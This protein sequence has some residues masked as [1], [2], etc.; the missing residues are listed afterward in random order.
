MTTYRRRLSRRTLLRG[1]ATVAIG[2]P[3]LE[4]MRVKS[5]W[6]QPAPPPVRAFNGFFGLGFPTPLQTEG[7]AGP[8]EPLGPLKDKLAILRGVSQVRCDVSGANAHF[9]GATGAFNATASGGE[10]KAGGPSLDQVLRVHAYPNGMPTHVTSTVLMGTYFRRSRVGR[11]V[12]AWNL[13]GSP[14]DLMR[15][16]PVELFERIFG[17]IPNDTPVDPAQARRT[18]LK[19]SV[20]DSVVEQ[21]RHYQSDASNLSLAS[22]ARIAQHLERLREYELRVY[23]SGSTTDPACAVPA[24]PGAS[25]IPH[26]SAADPGGEGIDITLTALV[27]EWR[28]MSDLFALGVH[29]D[30]VRFGAFT[31]QAAGERIRLKGTY[32]YAGRTIYNFDDASDL[33]ATGSLGCSHEFWHRF[34][35]SNPNTQLRAHVHLM[36]REIGY[37]LQQLDDPA[38]LDENGKTVLDNAMITISTESGD[39]RHNDVTR[40]LSGVFHAISGAGG[41]FKTG[42]IVDVNTSGLDVYN[43][44]LEAHGVTTRLGPST[45]PYNRVSSILV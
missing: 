9:D 29:C 34:N 24:Q 12:H 11:Y 37:L 8:L 1:A 42:Q 38:N 32:D 22:R 18:R 4:E 33:N 17:S 45:V 6:G 43:T 2:L 20:L 15:E 5:A 40:E 41:R 35:P 30:R 23:G 10:A 31:F 26:G 13:D 19:K 3:F 14:A 28:L 27:N 36:L 44:M 39:G 16:S 21:Y 7:Y 25:T